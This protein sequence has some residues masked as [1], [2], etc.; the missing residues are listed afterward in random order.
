MDSRCEFLEGG[1]IVQG[2]APVNLATA[3][4]TGD[5]VSLVNAEKVIVHFV[6]GV[7][8]AGDDP[9]ISLYQAKDASGTGAKALNFTKVRHKVGATAL[10]A[11]GQW[12]TASQSAE[13]SYDTDGI[14][15][16]E[17]E[18]Q[19]AIEITPDMLDG[20]NN[21]THIRADIADVG[22]NAQI[23]YLEYIVAGRSYKRSTPN[24]VI[25]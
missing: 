21:F 24:S 25:A 17:N 16:A 10:S 23:G 4:N 20:A 8:T 14:D 18:C 11:V 9:V 7:G 1:D 3:A 22:S 19:L 2:F 5:Y 6:S 15:G 13:S 12:T